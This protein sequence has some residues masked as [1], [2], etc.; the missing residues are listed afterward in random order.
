MT[1]LIK[2]ISCFFAINLS[3]C[4]AHIE[5]ATNAVNSLLTLTN[6]TGKYYCAKFID[7][8]LSENN[9]TNYKLEITKTNIILSRSSGKPI[10]KE[11]YAKI[12]FE[13]APELL[14]HYYVSQHYEF[15]LKYRKTVNNILKSN[16]FTFDKKF[17]NEWKK[18][19]ITMNKYDS[20]MDFLYLQ[21]KNHEIAYICL[22]NKETFDKISK[23]KDW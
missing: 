9:G 8:N 23:N 2:N 16:M 19:E 12:V 18:V 1:K 7:L 20:E 21:R 11:N 15:Y 22:E 4:Q 14:P 5:H 3:A 13:R 10:V 17:L 6:P